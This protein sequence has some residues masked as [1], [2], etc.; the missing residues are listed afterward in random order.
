MNGDED[1]R[2]NFLIDYSILQMKMMNV[3]DIIEFWK[4]RSSD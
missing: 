3:V 2:R 1:E 4:G